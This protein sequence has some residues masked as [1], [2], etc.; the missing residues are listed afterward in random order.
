MLT[1]EV[2]DKEILN[3]IKQNNPLRTLGLDGMQ[4]MFYNKS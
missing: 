4:A 2:F 1:M 3:Y